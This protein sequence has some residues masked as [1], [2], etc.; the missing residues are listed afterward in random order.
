MSRHP[1]SRRA[2][3]RVRKGP[4]A[5]SGLWCVIPIATPGA[6]AIL[7]RRRQ[8]QAGERIVRF[9][10]VRRGPWKPRGGPAP[11]VLRLND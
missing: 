3:R 6:T 4:K 10:L 5:T 9:T 11:M 7:K 2:H 8:K 1:F